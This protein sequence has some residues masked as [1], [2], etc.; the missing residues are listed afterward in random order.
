MEQASAFL[1]LLEKLLLRLLRYEGEYYDRA[2]D[3]TAWL[4]EGH[5]SL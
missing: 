1:N 3:E 5:S 4:P 2:N